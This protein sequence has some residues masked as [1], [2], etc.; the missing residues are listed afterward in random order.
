MQVILGNGAFIPDEKTLL[1]VGILPEFEPKKEE[2]IEI[3]GKDV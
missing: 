3:I 2:S 1:A